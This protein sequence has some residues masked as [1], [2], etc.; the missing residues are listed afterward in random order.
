MVGAAVDV[1]GGVWVGGGAAVLCSVCEA[2]GAS[3]V[4]DLS[5]RLVGRS[6]GTV[7]VLQETSSSGRNSRP[8]SSQIVGF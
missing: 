5:A 4:V 3:V 8:A 1:V 2:V 7:G 6:T